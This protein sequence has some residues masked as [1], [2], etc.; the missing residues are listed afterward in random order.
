MTIKVVLADDHKIVRQGLRVLL[1]SETDIEVVAEASNGLEAAPLVERIKPDILVADIRMP[2]LSGIELTRSVVK[3]S[4]G[5]A[6]IIL[7]MFGDEAYVIEGFQAG[8]RAYVAKES[9]VEELVLAIR[10]VLAGR[11]FIS[12]SVSSERVNAV[13]KGKVKKEAH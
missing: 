13:L 9:S 12:G 10:E 11:K 1:E 3:T 8:A 4:P 2:G 6:V 5:T 7:S